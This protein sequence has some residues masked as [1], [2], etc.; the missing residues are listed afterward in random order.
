VADWLSQARGA[1]AIDR[2]LDAAH[3]LF[4]RRDAATVGMH[5]VARAAGCSRATLYRYFE[6]RDALQTAYVHREAR[7]AFAG[8]GERLDPDAPSA[9]RLVDGIVEAVRLVRETPALASWFAPQQRPIGG[10]MAE[11]SE[12]IRAMVEAYGT[13]LGYADA[14]RRARWLVR[15]IVSLLTFPGDDAAD[16]RALLEDFVLPAFPD[17]QSTGHR[18]TATRSST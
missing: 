18:G 7:R 11:H 4:T 1:A 12:V 14:A 6:N 17:D 2:I 10:E 8:L 16:E 15:V 13:T 9:R 5:D 3:D